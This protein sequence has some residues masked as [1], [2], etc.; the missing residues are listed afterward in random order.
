MVRPRPGVPMRPRL[1]FVAAL[2]LVA[3]LVL[4]PAPARAETVET[5]Q[6]A[7]V[8]AAPGEQS[9]VVTRVRAGTE[10]SVL[11]RSGRWLKVKVAGKT[12]WITRSVLASD[13]ADQNDR[14]TR[15]KPFV[16]G[17]STRRGARDS[18]PDDKV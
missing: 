18:A 13:E 6:S 17:G 11:S 3:P 1:P 7:T 14:A 15:R 12:G 8:F 2:A 9:R 5:R 10:L 4:R 16:E